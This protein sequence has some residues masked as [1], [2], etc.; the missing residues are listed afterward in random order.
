MK[1]T[2][3]IEQLKLTREQI[4][5]AREDGLC[6][7]NEAAKAAIQRIHKNKKNLEERINKMCDSALNHI[8]QYQEEISK[9]IEELLKNNKL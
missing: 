7:L 6:Q 5:S 2:P 3:I 8:D 1:N 4:E 9:Q